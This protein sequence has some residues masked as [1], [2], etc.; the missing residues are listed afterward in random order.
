MS[1]IVREPIIKEI[2]VRRRKHNVKFKSFVRMAAFVG[3]LSVTP[4]NLLL[5][6]VLAIVSPDGLARTAE[7]IWMIA[8]QTL[9]SMAA[10]ASIT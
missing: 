7:P 9:A 10:N 8:H 5:K 4:A 1:A 6:L 3:K 2:F